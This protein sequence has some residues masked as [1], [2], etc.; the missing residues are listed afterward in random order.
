MHPKPSIFVLFALSCCLSC[1][2]RIER[3]PVSAENAAEARRFTLQGDVLLREGKDHLALLSYIE[4]STHDPYSPAIFNKLA[5]SYS[6]LL[7]F[8]RAWRS[9]QRSI[10]LDPDYAFAY[11][12]RGTILLADRR[13][14]KAIGSFRKAIK[15]RPSKPIFYLNLASAYLH[16]QHYPEAREAIKKAVALDP[17]VMLLEGVLQVASLANEPN[18]ERDYKIAVLFAEVG[19]LE[20]TLTYLQK[21]LSAGFRDRLRIHRE[22]A[23]RS[24]LQQP[25]FTQLLQSFG[26]Q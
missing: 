24:M 6:R 3:L 1:S 13:P 11:N 17:D 23:F 14:Q 18:P 20:S 19:H 5:I 21:A 15:I 7:Q 16:S 8:D 22:A 2:G 9:I 25:Q 4:A 26:L 12:T 10:R